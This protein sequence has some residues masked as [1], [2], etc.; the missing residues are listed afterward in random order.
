MAERRTP[1]HASHLRSGAQVTRGSGD[2]M[3]AMVYTTVAEEHI[4]TRTHVGMQDL[5]TM[6][7]VD[8]KGPGAESLVNYLLVNDVRCMLPGQV[9][10][11]TACRED[12]GILDDL[13]AFRLGEEHF[14][15]VC[16]SVN[17][18]KMVDWITRHAEGRA[19]YVTD[20]TAALAM[21]AIQGPRSRE[22]LKSIVQEADLNT[23][24]HFRFAR[25]RIGDTRLI[26]SRTGVTGELG[27]EL[28]IPSDEAPPLWDYLLEAGRDFGLKPYGRLAMF[29]LG[30]EK[31]YPA[32]GIDMDESRTPFHLGLDRW[33]RF[34]KGD[35]IGRDALL[36]VR[37]KGVT[38]HWIGL[39]VEGR[40]AAAASDPVFAE[41]QVVGQVT[42]SNEG[43]SVGKILATAHVKT[44]HTRAGT[45]LAISIGGARIPAKV[46]GMPFFDPEGA[47]LKS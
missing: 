20:M 37:E 1:F 27:F 15:L 33:V 42:Y 13:T 46:V 29:T 3:C 23:L 18:G 2:F 11:S 17:R 28:Y 41:D 38:E 47:R 9:R 44:E 25:A 22:F 32:H 30:L 34:D 4:N 19:A 14:M 5:S 10:Y 31:G 21:A 43:Y 40:R 8:I 6:G 12:G 35:F 45:D 26:A 36:C 7:K 24:K 39:I 16:G